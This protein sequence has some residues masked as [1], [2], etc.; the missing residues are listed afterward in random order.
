M[1]QREY[2]GPWMDRLGADVT[3]RRFLGAGAG[4]L[5]AIALGGLAACG[6][7]GD[8]ASKSGGTPASSD[9]SPKRGGTIKV[10]VSDQTTKDSYDPQRNSSTLGLMSA[11]MMYDTLLKIDDEWAVSPMLAEDF[12][13][14]KDAKTYT[15]KLRKGIEF[16]NG[17]PLEAEDVQYTFRRMLSGG[18]DLHGDAIFGPVLDAKGIVAVDPTTVRFELKEPDGF[19]P[20]K[21]AFWYGRIIQR[22]ADFSQSA[23][24]G[25]FKGISFKGGQG[26]QL[27]RNPNYW[28]D[29]LPYLDGITGIAVTDVATKLE[30]VLS[31]DVDFCDP[32]DFSAV[33]QIESA[34]SVEALVA[35]FGFPYVMG[36]D[37]STKPYS[38]PRVRKAMKHLID[39]DKYVTIVAQGQAVA[40]PDLFVNPKDPF[41]P[42][43]LEAPPYDPEMAK[44]LLKEAGYGDGFKEEAWTTPL[45]GMPEMTTLFKASMAEGGIDIDIKN[46]PTEQWASQLFKKPI[47]NNYWGRQH[48]ST[49]APY[50]A[51]TGGQWNEARMSDPQIDKWIAEAQATPDL[52][53][54][55]EIYAELGRRYAEET[56]CIWPFASKGL[57]PHKKRLTG[58][59]T[60]PTDLVD[61][62]NASIAA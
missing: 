11:G 36:I 14:S 7:D 16:H 28:Q 30:S 15:F 27:E 61:F 31:G 22:D 49:M 46:V 18:P 53:R 37:G 13:A 17:Q 34:S 54:Q 6:D 2:D 26:F 12:D 55:K 35:E 52:E 59:T 57:W 4:A 60:N 56:S 38:D 21:L 58:L 19:L 33:K 40:S 39:R 10:S 8:K 41:F 45:P 20:V 32:G 51:K 48:P 1:G 50:M 44:S 43:G 25:P 24:T 3:R 29:G 5:G 47:V 23:G 42:T 62:R 9:G